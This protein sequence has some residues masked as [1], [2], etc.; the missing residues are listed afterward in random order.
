MRYVLQY[1]YYGGSLYA[2]L[3]NF[4]RAL[5]FFEICLSVPSQQTTS[6]IQVTEVKVKCPRFV[7][8]TGVIGYGILGGGF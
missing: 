7:L 2:A 3:R 1:Y 4:S 6:A 8:S 5:H